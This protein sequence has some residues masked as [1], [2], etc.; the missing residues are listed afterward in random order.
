MTPANLPPSNYFE[1]DYSATTHLEDYFYYDIF[2]LAITLH[3]SFHKP[4][5]T[6]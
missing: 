1:Q 6:L 4:T 3:H 2:D 5:V